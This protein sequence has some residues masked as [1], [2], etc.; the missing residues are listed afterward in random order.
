MENEATNEQAEAA[1]AV[2]DEP[3]T[4]QA[5]VELDE[6]EAAGLK[7]ADDPSNDAYEDKPDAEKASESDQAE[8]ADDGPALKPSKKAVDGTAAD[9]EM[10]KVAPD[11]TDTKKAADEDAEV[12]EAETADPGLLPDPAVLSPAIKSPLV[13]S[14]DTLLLRPVP[15]G[16]EL[17]G[18]N[19]GLIISI[20]NQVQGWYEYASVNA[21]K[22]NFRVPRDHPASVVVV[23]NPYSVFLHVVQCLRSCLFA[24]A[25]VHFAE[26][27]DMAGHPWWTGV[28]EEAFDTASAGDASGKCLRDVKALV[29]SPKEDGKMVLEH[30]IGTGWSLPEHFHLVRV[31]C[32]FHYAEEPQCAASAEFMKK[33]ELHQAPE[34]IEGS[35]VRPQASLAIK[36][37][38]LDLIM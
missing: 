4:I 36:S 27:A 23:T 30:I 11:D 8:A 3:D 10:K 34:D 24:E 22:T 7:Q 18:C 9:G 38:L 31:S 26:E 15:R 12:A 33:M 20:S 1:A 13:A 17:L 19:L 35:K 21:V 32:S 28:W 37:T 5:A 25:V 16:P 14:R 29:F 2:V 6:P